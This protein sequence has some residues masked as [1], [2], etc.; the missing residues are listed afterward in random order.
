MPESFRLESIASY[1]FIDHGAP[2]R[3]E[4]PRD[5]APV[6][7]AACRLASAAAGAAVGST[8]VG[9]AGRRGMGCSWAARSQTATEGSR[10]RTRS[11]SVRTQ[12]GDYWEVRRSWRLPPLAASARRTTCRP[13]DTPLG[14]PAANDKLSP[15]DAR[16]PAALRPDQSSLLSLHDTRAPRPDGRPRPLFHGPRHEPPPGADKAGTRRPCDRSGDARLGGDHR[17]DRST[18]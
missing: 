11:G 2:A 10:P 14:Q 8:G 13:D 15:Q 1:D 12:G 3:A 17:R 4:E 6:S 16:E 9:V 5:A 7:A 18:R